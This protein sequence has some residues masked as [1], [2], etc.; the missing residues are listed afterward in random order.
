MECG[1]F[2]AGLCRSCSWLETRYPQQ[3]CGK[4][5]SVTQILEQA[6]VTTPRTSPDFRWLNPLTSPETGFRNKAKMTVCGTKTD[7]R[8][9]LAP[10]KAH[11]QGVDLCQCPLYEAPIRQALP[12]V[13][14]WLAGL[15]ARPYQIE[16]DRGELKGVI[17]SCNPGGE[18]ALRLVL[19]SPAA[20][21][22]IKK[23]W[24]Q[25]RA[26]LPGLKV[27][28]LNL[29]PLHAAIL[30]G[31]EEILVS[32]TSHLEMP[33]L[34]TNLALAPGAFFQTNTA[35]ALGLY[36]Q[37]HDW[38]AQLRPQQ[39]WDL[40][41]GVGGFAFAAA[42]A[43]FE[44]SGAGFEVRGQ[45]GH[46]V[47]EGGHAVVEG[48]HA[49]GGGGVVTGVEI[50]AS[51]IEAAKAAKTQWEV[52]LAPAA[53]GLTAKPQLNFIAADAT[54][55]AR[56]QPVSTHPQLVIVNPPRRGLGAELRGWLESSRC[57]YLIYSSCN[58]RSLATDLQALSSYSLRQARIVDMFPHTPHVECVCLLTRKM[59]QGM[60][61][62]I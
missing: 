58:P 21:G 18:T 60:S 33:G 10:T 3:V 7:I 62:L 5:A 55:W 6:G 42:T 51:S 28:S 43:L 20:L 2:E 1:Y 37:A 56:E 30:E 14:D 25:L 46:A 27:F 59:S 13:R 8:L 54:R 49:V 44:E 35:A 52:G 17:L 61:T 23:T 36:R 22:R 31:P 39:V 57:Q 9:G 48:G 16:R 24:G 29:Q 40:Y 50:T 34:G 4:Q 45:G 19:R 53:Q 38:V 32:Q 11:P 41:C 47:V 15:G 12:V 26:A